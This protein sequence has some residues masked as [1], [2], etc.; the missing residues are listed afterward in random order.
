MKPYNFYKSA[1]AGFTLVELVITMTIFIIVLII[2]SDAF[3]KIVT[4][5]SK[6]SRMEESNIEGVIG[7][8][9]MRH[10]LEQAGFGLPWGWG[11]PDPL[12]SGSIVPSSL[13]VDNTITLSYSEAADTKGLTLNDS[14]NGVPRAVAASAVLGQFSSA[15]IAIKGST[16]GGSKAS[17]RWTNIPYHNYS[18]NPR[19]SRPV[20]GAG[21]PAVDDRVIMI[22]ANFNDAN[23]DHRLIVDSSSNT[24]YVNYKL[25]GLSDDYV[26]FNE[27]FSYMVYG[28]DDAN[29]RMPFNRAD[30][31]IRIPADGTLPPFCGPRTGVLYKATINHDGGGYRFMPLLDCVADMQV[32]F[33]WDT[34]DDG[35]AGQVDVYSSALKSGGNYA[36]SV[37][38]SDSKYAAIGSYFSDPEAVRK[39][40]KMIKVYILAQDG[41]RDKS[42]SAPVTTIEVGDRLTNGFD[43]TKFYSLSSEQRQYRWKLYRIVARPKNL[44]SN[45]R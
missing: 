44:P 4:Q 26:P 37:P 28:I 30:F 11:Q 32:V 3:N 42:Y 21:T 36:A 24:F 41:K 27:L 20:S 23:L 6:L 18:A 22:T 38:S 8:E 5:S 25:S 35:G 39:H 40:L 43:V 10:D 7:L 14:P 15:H 33:G 2:A 12:S 19:E 34:S 31:F 17:Q 29:P 16:L 45:Q 9:I 1:Q 13:L